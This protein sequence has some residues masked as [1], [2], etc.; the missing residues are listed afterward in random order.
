MID[1]LLCSTCRQQAQP[2]TAFGW[3]IVERRPLTRNG[4]GERFTFCSGRCAA[5]GLDRR[6]PNSFDRRE[7]AAVP[8]RRHLRAVP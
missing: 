3:L 2:D 5:A 8:G 6:D 4:V 1:L 7:P